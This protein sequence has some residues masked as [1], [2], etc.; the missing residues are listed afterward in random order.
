MREL[1]EKT[2]QIIKINPNDYKIHLTCK[3]PTSYDYSPVEITN[4]E[5]ICIM[6]ELY[7]QI[8]TVE[9]YVE[10]IPFIYFEICF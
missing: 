5:D 7:P 6:L 3:W 10:N 4:D 9:L 1:V 2:H 8:K